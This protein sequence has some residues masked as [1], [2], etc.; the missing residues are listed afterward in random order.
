VYQDVKKAKFINMIKITMDIFVLMTVI[1]I[2]IE[3]VQKKVFKDMDG[4]KTLNKFKIKI[5]LQKID[6]SFTTNI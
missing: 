4:V 3:N 2:K 5:I 1:V 6:S